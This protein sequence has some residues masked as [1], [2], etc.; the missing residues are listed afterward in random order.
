MRPK[1]IRHRQGVSMRPLLGLACNPYGLMNVIVE[2]IPEGM[3]SYIK[4]IR[5]ALINGHGP[6]EEFFI[7]L[8]SKRPQFTN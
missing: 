2:S 6:Y 5:A 7:S 8:N 4:L 3:Y 1:P